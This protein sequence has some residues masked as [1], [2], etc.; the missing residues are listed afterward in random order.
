MPRRDHHRCGRTHIELAAEA[1]RGRRKDETEAVDVRS[2]IDTSTKQTDLLRR[3]IR[4]FPREIAVDDRKRS[5]IC[6][7]GDAEIDELGVVDVSSRKEDVLW[8]YVPVNDAH[9]MRRGEAARQ[10]VAQTQDFVRF[11]TP[12]A[13]ELLQGLSVHVL[14]YEITQPVLVPEKPL[15]VDYR[16]VFYP[17][18]LACFFTK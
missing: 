6:R 1:H 13:Q 10:P 14:C 2:Q 17:A 12:L 15:V 4:V 9:L 5:R 16:I 18:Q 8:R 11:K 3:D 7:F